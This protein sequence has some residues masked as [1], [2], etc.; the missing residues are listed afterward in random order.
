MLN[1]ITKVVEMTG[2]MNTHCASL[3]Q[4]SLQSICLF[5][6]LQS[7]QT[8]NWKV[9][10]TKIWALQKRSETHI[11]F[12]Q[13]WIVG[14]SNLTFL[15]VQQACFKRCSSISTHQLSTLIWDRFTTWKCILSII[16]KTNQMFWAQLLLYFLTENMEVILQIHFLIAFNSITH[17][18]KSLS[19]SRIW[20]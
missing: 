11:R 13:H 18:M 1:L 7:N 5:Q 8:W 16:I 3:E 20:T 12:K 4:N 14:S 15:M 6:V 2:E 19:L 10:L 9:T 17:L